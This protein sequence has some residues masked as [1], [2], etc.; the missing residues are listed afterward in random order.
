MMI[1]NINEF[2]GYGAGAANAHGT[3][4]MSSAAIEWMQIKQ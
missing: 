4:K 1:H 3:R 2:L